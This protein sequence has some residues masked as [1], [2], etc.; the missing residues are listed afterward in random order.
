MTRNCTL[1]VMVIMFAVIVFG[2]ITSTSAQA[3][4][5]TLPATQADEY[6]RKLDQFKSEYSDTPTWLWEVRKAPTPYYLRGGFERIHDLA[7]QIPVELP[8]L[9]ADAYNFAREV[10]RTYVTGI[11]QS[12]EYD[13]LYPPLELFE[14]AT[15]LMITA[16]LQPNEVGT[17]QMRIRQ[18]IIKGIRG[19]MRRLARSF[20]KSRDQEL[21]TAATK[22]IAYWTYKYNLEARDLEL[23]SRELD[24][25]MERYKSYP[26][27]QY[28]PWS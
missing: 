9:K 1:R 22:Q 20:L 4:T 12:A 13:E 7:D 21:Q 23:K 16:G 18:V 3:Q 10:A 14:V 2:M 8:A 19:E 6:T 24:A 17:S 26:D 15:E 28:Y 25:I 11:W 27:R 5:A